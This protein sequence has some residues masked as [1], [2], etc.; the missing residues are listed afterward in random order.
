MRRR[1]L[2][3]VLSEAGIWLLSAFCALAV[4]AAVKVLTATVE[5]AAGTVTGVFLLSLVIFSRKYGRGR[6][7]LIRVVRKQPGATSRPVRP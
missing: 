5:A 7:H 4:A 6:G 3:N 1:L 2:A